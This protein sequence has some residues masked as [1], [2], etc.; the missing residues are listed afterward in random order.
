[1]LPLELVDLV[2]SFCID[3]YFNVCLV[4]K[5]F[6]QLAARYK[7]AVQAK[8]TGYRWNECCRRGWLPAVQWLHA[9]HQEGCTDDAM[10]L[11]AKYGHL[12][13]VKWLHDNRE[14]GCTHNAMDLAAMNGNLHVVQWLHAIR[15]EGCTHWAMD[16]A[17]E[18]GHFHVVK[19]LHENMEERRI[20]RYVFE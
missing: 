10:N 6:Y 19:W 2:L 12:E 1:M 20:R 11:A 8:K 9:N 15:G 7:G 13:V 3:D 4:S 17:A 16:W 5:T 18:N 14:E